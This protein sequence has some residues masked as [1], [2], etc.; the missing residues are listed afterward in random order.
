MGLTGA[1]ITGVKFRCQK[2]AQKM[3]I[4]SPISYKSIYCSILVAAGGSIYLL[5]HLGDSW[6]GLLFRAAA[7]KR[8]LPHNSTLRNQLRK[9]QL[10]NH[11]ST[12]TF[13]GAV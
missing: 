10:R 1:N 8:S 9:F 6:G 4:S 13:R 12:V 5:S 2:T 3:S 7:L 11:K